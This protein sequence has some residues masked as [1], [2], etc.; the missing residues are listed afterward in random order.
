MRNGLSEVVAVAVDTVGDLIRERRSQSV[1][2]KVAAQRPSVV[3]TSWKGV[4]AGLSRTDYGVAG[5][6]ATVTGGTILRWLV[7]FVTLDLSLPL[8]ETCAIRQY[9]MRSS[10][11]RYRHRGG[12]DAAEKRPCY[13]TAPTKTLTDLVEDFY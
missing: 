1:L 8:C 4:I 10:D 2:E 12:M 6:H 13:T 3:Y 5:R 7:A 11:R 9:I